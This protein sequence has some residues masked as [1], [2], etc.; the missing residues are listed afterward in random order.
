[1]AVK[2]GKQV[3]DALNE[4]LT[5]ELTAINQYF[6]HAKMLENW[7]FLG[8]AGKVRAESIDEM[9]HADQLI[10]RILYLEGVPNVQKLGRVRIGEDVAEMWRS[11]LT[12][13]QE[14]IPRLNTA[15][16]L[17]RDQA[18][19]GTRQLLD[20]I[21]ASE[22]EHLDWLETQLHLIDTVGLQAYLAQHIDA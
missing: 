5:A 8:L 16:A 18:D 22:E 3:I 20:E 11:D 6:L 4:V 17:C 13:E 1:M 12:L 7:G 2:A 15:I 9:K 21:L 10:D 14:A 19:N